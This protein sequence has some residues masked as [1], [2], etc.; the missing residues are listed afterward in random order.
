[1]LAADEETLCR[2]LSCNSA[3][4][5]TSNVFRWTP[6]RMPVIAQAKTWAS[7]LLAAASHAAFRTLATALFPR[8]ARCHAGESRSS[9]EPILRQ[10]HKA[11]RN[12]LT[13]WSRKRQRYL[14]ERRGVAASQRRR[15]AAT[16]RWNGSHASNCGFL[17]KSTKTQAFAL[18][19]KGQSK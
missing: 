7:P 19:S 9:A 11:A 12:A 16:K 10:T 5:P 8:M 4:L 13:K 14:L 15:L 1:M 2:A 3:A 17:V 18:H 6:T